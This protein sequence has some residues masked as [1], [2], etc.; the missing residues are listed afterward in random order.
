M[1]Q[2]ADTL[3][4]IRQR[5][6]AAEVAV[7]GWT[8]TVRD[9]NPHG[10][11]P[12][13]LL[14]GA[15]GTGDVFH[16]VIDALADQRRLVS[17]SYPAL[18]DA[19]ALAG[20]IWQM[21]DRLGVDSADLLGSSLGGYLAQVCALQQPTR[22]RRAMLACTFYDS[23]WLQRRIPPGP[24]AATPAEQHMAAT[25]AGWQAAPEDSDAAR[26]LKSTMLALLGTHQTAETAKAALLAVLRAPVLPRLELPAAEVALL[27]ADDDPVVDAA[28]RAQMRERY[29]GHPQFRLAY[30]GHY[31]SLLN[32][33]AFIAAVEQHFAPRNTTPSGHHS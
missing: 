33:A 29:A 27:D 32:P 26:E 31:P 6:P 23:A 24:W 5:F 22:V 28:T 4:K 14:P 16:R 19:V 15:G 10:G 12:L 11:M 30:G 7:D 13:L 25:I 20:G 21:L 3:E 1:K 9:T 2:P 17:V 8:W 18:P